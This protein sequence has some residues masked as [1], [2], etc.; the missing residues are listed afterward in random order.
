MGQDDEKG[1]VLQLLGLREGSER[2]VQ[3]PIKALRGWHCPPCPRGNDPPKC[4]SQKLLC[5]PKSNPSVLAEVPHRANSHS[6]LQQTQIPVG[7]TLSYGKAEGEAGGSS[8]LKV[9]TPARPLGA[10][11][12]QV[13][14]REAFGRRGAIHQD[15]QSTFGLLGE[16]PEKRHGISFKKTQNRTALR[17][18]LG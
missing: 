5:T 8:Q 2:G 9:L 18:T 3:T 7:S 15:P 13:R 11:K 16:V 6:S 1:H 10:K 4:G 14:V 17:E 12:G